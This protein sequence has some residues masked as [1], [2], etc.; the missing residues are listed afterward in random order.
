MQIAIIAGGRG[1]RLAP[2]TDVIPK[3]MVLVHGKPFLEHEIMLLKENGVLDFVLCVGYLSKVIMDHF[4]D[5]KRFGVRI[6]YSDDGKKPLGVIG[7]L[8]NAEPLLEDY[9]FMTYGDAY[10]RADYSHAMKE[11]QHSEKLGMMFVYENKNKFGRSDVEVRDGLVASY[12][13]KNQTPDMTFINYGLIALR[14]E[15]LT[16]VPV[17]SEFGEQ[18]F[19]GQLIRENELVAHVT[20][21]RFYEIGSKESLEEFRKFISSTT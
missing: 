5:G 2:I 9:F 6:R 14:R 11:F 12:D 15:A 18:E 3:P 8:K 4:G 7:S 16:R 10:L 17:G 19:F 20:K 21:E 1:T 13:K